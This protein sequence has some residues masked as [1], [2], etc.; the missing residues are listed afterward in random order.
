[1]FPLA[2][3]TAG[4]AN[5]F[6]SSMPRS[7]G[8]SW[9]VPIIDAVG[10]GGR[11]VLRVVEGERPAPDR[12]PQV[13]RLEP[14]HQLEDLRVHLAVEAAR[15]PG[16]QAGAEE[17]RRPAAQVRVLVIDEEAPVLHH[18]RALGMPSGQH[19]QFAG[20]A[21]RNVIPPVP[22]GDPDLL[23]D[24]VGAEDGPA[25]VAAGDHERAANTGQRVLHHLLERC[26]PSSGYS[27]DIQR[28]G[29]NQLVD[30]RALADRADEHDLAIRR[31]LIDRHGWPDSGNRC[32]VGL[33]V[34]HD[35]DYARVI[36]AA[37]HKRRG[38]PISHERKAPRSRGGCQVRLL[39]AARDVLTRVSRLRERRR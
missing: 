11:V 7:I 10:G 27:A 18:R 8:A 39:I 38:R 37:N 26:L 17:F 34:A 13:V 24:V 25:L 36:A 5:R 6:H 3:R 29:G 20:M 35:P 22:R 19:V 16:E 28:P 30:Q 31:H 9:E 32:D 33:Q 1:M 21:R 14:E 12:G 4:T 2:S 23:R 15:E